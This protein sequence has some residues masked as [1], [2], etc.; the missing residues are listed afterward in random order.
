MVYNFVSETGR[1][2]TKYVITKEGVALTLSQLGVI[3][4]HKLDVIKNHIE[5]EYYGSVDKEGHI[6]FINKMDAE[7]F[8]QAM[9]LR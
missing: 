5:R 2:T 6:G 8:S 7:R 3:L 9:N 4:N 1:H